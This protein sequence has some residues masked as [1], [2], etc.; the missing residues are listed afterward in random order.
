MLGLG[1]PAP[2]APTARSITVRWEC[3]WPMPGRPG[4]RGWT[5]AHHPGHVR[6]RLSCHPPRRPD[7][8][9]GSN[10]PHDLIPL[11]SNEISRLLAVAQGGGERRPPATA[12]SPQPLPEKS[13][14]LSRGGLVEPD[15]AGTGDVRIKLDVV[16]PRFPRVPLIPTWSRWSRPTIVNAINSAA[17]LSWDNR[18]GYPTSRPA[19]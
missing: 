6:R 2:T 15:D 16:G 18:M 4:G 13:E 17:S 1:T 11:T 7:Q 10:R 14:K 9:R 3:F 12:R 19:R 5:A 8:K